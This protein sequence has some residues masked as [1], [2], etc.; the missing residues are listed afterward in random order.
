MV[1]GSQT[2]STAGTY[3]VRVTIRHKLGVTTPTEVSST[4]VVTRQGFGQTQNSEYWR[5][6]AGQNLINRFNGAATS[7]QLSNWLATTF[8]RLYGPQAGANNLTG[9]TNAQVA[10]YYA[11]LFNR[12]STA[13]EREVLATALNIYASTLNLGGAAGALAGFQVTSS[14]LGATN[15]NVGLREVH[16]VSQIIHP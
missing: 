2:Y 4:A 5:G 11:S 3:A 14:G 1:V 16:L 8:P 7:T 12:S 9:R 10:A 6:Q 15:V 13:L